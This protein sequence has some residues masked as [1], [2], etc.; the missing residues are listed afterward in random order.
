MVGLS[1]SIII[2]AI[3]QS[4]DIVPEYTITYNLTQNSVVER[5]IRTIKNKIRAII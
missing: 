4:I 2:Q 1:V 5:G 3:N